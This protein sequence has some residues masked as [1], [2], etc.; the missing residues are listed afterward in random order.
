[1]K[2]IQ[3]N[4][5]DEVKELEGFLSYSKITSLNRDP[6]TAFTHKSSP[7]MEFGSLVDALLSETKEGF[8]EKYFIMPEFDITDKMREFADQFIELYRIDLIEDEI[9][10][11]ARQI[12]GFNKQLKDETVIKQFKESCGAYI[13]CVFM[14][15][16][17]TIVGQ[18]DYNDA[19]KLVEMI[20][21]GPYTKDLFENSNYTLLW[22]VPFAIKTEY[23]DFKGIKDLVVIDNINKTVRTIDLKTTS[24]SYL[25]FEE[26]Y[27]KWRYDVQDFIYTLDNELYAT[28][29]G[30]M[31]LETR[32]LIAEKS[33]EH[34]P[35]FFQMDD[36]S[37]ILS[38]KGLDSIRDLILNANWYL[39]SQSFDF[40][41]EVQEN[42]G[43]LV[44]E[45][46]S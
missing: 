16:G 3:V 7:A 1:M 15:K 11:H 26:S 20:K 6:S 14:A 40:I 28:E 8:E 29:N 13:E 25:K 12:V 44:K 22:Q 24:S 34:Y 10:L 35:V 19:V 5:K 42:N 37:P 2:R 27:W 46:V 38:P 36:V 9:I 18:S 23:G 45:Y 43:V 21:T 33:M 17:K 31:P 4:N 39:K 32:F 30:L 41:K